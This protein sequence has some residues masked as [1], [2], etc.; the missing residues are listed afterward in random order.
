MN[1]ESKRSL[2]TRGAGANVWVSRGVNTSI[3]TEVV[4]TEGISVTLQSN[5]GPFGKERKKFR[6]KTM[7][8]VN[9]VNRTR[10]TLGVSWS[11]ITID[12]NTPS[13]G[14]SFD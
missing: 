3:G 11:F 2:R 14:L 5:Q 7:T 8:R 13:H 4:F 12:N 1:L 9:R 10:I 6:E